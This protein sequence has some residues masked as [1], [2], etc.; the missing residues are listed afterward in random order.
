MPAH[1]LHTAAVAVADSLASA[2]TTVTVQPPRRGSRASDPGPVSPTRDD[3]LVRGLSEVV[4]GPVGEHA[5][6][7][8]WWSPLRV[9]LVV[10]AV[11]MAVG[12]LGK[13]PCTGGQWLVG[14]QRFT[15]LC[16][17]DVASTYT[18][19]GY[20]EGIWPWTEDEQIRLR[21]P[22]GTQPALTSYAAWLAARVTHSLSGSP[23]LAARSALTVAEVSE[24]PEVKRE[25]RLFTV[26]N[27]LLLA[28]LGLLAAAAVTL[29]DR[30]RP[31][32]GAA[33]AAAPL[34]AL[35]WLTSWQLAAAAGVAGALWAWS[36]GR[37]AL[38]GLCVALAASVSL[39]AA[40]VLVAVVGVAARARQWRDLA[41]AVA[42]GV[43]AFVVVQLPAWATGPSTW[44]THWSQAWDSRPEIG[45]VWL[46]V[47]QVRDIELHPAGL[48]LALMLG[49]SVALVVLALRAPSPPRLAQLGL[50]A[51]A[52][53][54][55]LGD[56]GSP[57]YPLVLLPLAAAAVPRWRD[58]LVWQGCEVFH[59]VMT[60][61]YLGAELAPGAGGD[62][63]AYWLAII[64][65]L[66][67]LLWLV[68]V[69]VRDLW[70]PAQETTTESNAVAV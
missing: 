50:L 55:L 56:A 8:P 19:A 3:S 9:V 33:F 22:V 13:A 20:A 26:I 35:A 58:L 6:R 15:E 59:L 29:L 44:R 46:L 57:S 67:G 39:P 16:W 17:S 14:D 70:W 4:G 24:R 21:Y 52:A 42:A 54:L 34:L 43:V 27:G 5:S 7:H 2:G 41:L 25:A 45:S 49:Y 36:R 47:E 23:D 65:R 61:F 11:V 68:G 28:A 38:A 51:V 69:V 62:A 63:K 48:T 60:G 30:R 10:A 66:I 32:D 12:M 18:G 53:A 37:P 64:V 1:R 31:W 40:M